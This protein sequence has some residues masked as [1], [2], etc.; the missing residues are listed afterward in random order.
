MNATEYEE[1]LQR[2]YEINQNR[3]RNSMNSLGSVNQRTSVKYSLSIGNI[4]KNKIN[5]IKLPF[6]F[7][8]LNKMNRSI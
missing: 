2:V 8:I 5:L 4:F 6:L 3:N 7:R 1:L